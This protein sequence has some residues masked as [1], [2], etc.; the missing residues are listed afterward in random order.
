STTAK[1]VLIEN[2]KIIYSK[3]ERHYSKVR[4]KIAEML[5][6]IK[7]IV[8]TNHLRTAIS[9]SAG[10]GI[11]NELGLAFV[12]EVYAAKISVSRYI[13]EKILNEYSL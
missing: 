4:E 8:G 6:V 2:E 11:A 1:I 13:P 7:P 12:Q 9:G 3:Y 10:M 5:S